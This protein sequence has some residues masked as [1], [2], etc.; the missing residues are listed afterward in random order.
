MIGPFRVVLIITS[1]GAM[2][3]ACGGSQPPISRSGEVPQAPATTR[4]KSL[5][6][7]GSGSD[8]QTPNAALIDV[9]GALYGTTYRGG[10]Y[11]DGT[12]FSMSTTGTENVL[13][14]FQGG[15]DGANPSASLL[16]VKSV[17]YGTTEYGGREF[18]AGTV[19]KISA[20]G[21][22]KV[23]H[24]FGPVPDGLFPVASLIDVKGTL[25]GTTSQ[26]GDDASCDDG[27]GTVYSISKN[28]KEKV[29]HSFTA[30]ADGVLPLAS[31]IDVKGT[32][33]GTTAAGIGS[34][35]N[36]TGFGTVFE[37][38]TMG[39]ESVLYNFPDGGFHGYLPAS[40]LI[41][42]NG[43][44]YG[45]TAG[46]SAYSGSV[47]RGTAFSITTSGSLTT[48][49][50]FGSGPDGGYPYAPLLNVKGTLYGTTSSGGTYGKGTVFSLALT[51]TDEKVLHSFG[52]GPDG[53][54]PLAGL[55]DVNGT[56]YGTT[57]AG[58][59]HRKGTVFALTP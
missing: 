13:Y 46:G 20:G 36:N 50:S 33:Y 52:H 53:A 14:S 8:G 25:Y 42:V 40:G 37:V 16:T 54:T 24:N 35:G 45:T 58:G 29:L 4:Y 17:L 48:L 7:F 56:L 26:G 41:N 27:C 1:A 11:A 12:V 15:S 5:Y 19:F 59:A 49:H 47:G 28:G 38:S 51:G 18:D 10:G 9:N 55:I 23:L 39:T 2:L 44:L 21:R 6:S 34:P 3:A 43:T 30:Y 57:S 22:E 32:L 31:L